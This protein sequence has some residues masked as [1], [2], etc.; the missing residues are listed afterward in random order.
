MR[1]EEK[2][3]TTALGVHNFSSPAMRR[4]GNVD[5]AQKKKGGV[6]MAHTGSFSHPVR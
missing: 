6:R 3:Q 5:T 1:G 2:F 4:E